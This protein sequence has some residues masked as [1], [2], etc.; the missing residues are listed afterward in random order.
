M[1]AFRLHKF[2]TSYICIQGI[3]Q[4]HFK[5]QIHDEQ[6]GKYFAGKLLI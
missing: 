6:N 3:E 2:L 4:R 5:I 1:I